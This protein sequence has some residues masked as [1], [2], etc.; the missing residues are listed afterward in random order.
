[1]GVQISAILKEEDATNIGREI[2]YLDLCD[3]KRDIWRYMNPQFRR[4]RWEGEE[5]GVEKEGIL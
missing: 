2:H 5:R 3:H 4:A 1:M